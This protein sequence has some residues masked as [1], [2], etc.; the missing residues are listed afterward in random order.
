MKGMIQMS[1]TTK[2]KSILNNL[3][4]AASTSND[5][6]TLTV[7]DDNYDLFVNTDD[8]LIQSNQMKL[9]CIK[10]KL[11]IQ[12]SFNKLSIS[13]S[14]KLFKVLVKDPKIKFK[15]N[16]NAFK[17][18]VK[19]SFLVV[20]ISTPF[21]ISVKKDVMTFSSD[22]NETL[23]LKK[24][25]TTQKKASGCAIP[26]NKRLLIS[27]EKNK[28]FLPYT[29]EELMKKMESQKY[30]TVEDLIDAEYIVCNDY[31]KFPI[32]ARFKEGYKLIRNKEHGNR[33]KA[34]DLGFELALN[35]SLNP[36]I[37]TACKNLEELNIYLD[38]L[39]ENELNKFVCFDIIYEINPA[40]RT[41]LA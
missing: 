38:C 29:G 10:N 14:S 26:D 8:V 36:A 20:S 2:D 24:E 3:S 40:T 33:K 17:V 16:Q 15:D 28:T 1:K 22:N 4:S 37:I 41:N 34:V 12:N 27:E 39:E 32:I 35:F 6:F 9:S 31:Y 21:R 25:T 5:V 18:K 13:K 30:K 19:D 23:E 11:E 7:P